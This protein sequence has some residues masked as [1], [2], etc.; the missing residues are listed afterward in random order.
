[1]CVLCALR[2]RTFVFLSFG[3]SF[4]SIFIIATYIHLAPYPPLLTCQFI[5]KPIILLLFFW[6]YLPMVGGD[7]EIFWE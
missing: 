7:L 2:W 3:P 4:I 5:T 6:F 1:M